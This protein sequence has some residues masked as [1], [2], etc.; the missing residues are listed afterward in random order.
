MPNAAGILH[1]S[2]L[3]LGRDFDDIGMKATDVQR[4]ARSYW[5]RGGLI[6]QAH[7]PFIIASLHSNVRMAARRLGLAEDAFDLM[8]VTGD[9]STTA[10]SE[11]R[12]KFARSFLT[13]SF[14]YENIDI[15]LRFADDRVLCVPGNHDKMNEKTCARYL[16]HFDNLPNKPPYVLEKSCNGVRFVFYGI[17]SNLY[18]EGNVALGKIRTETLAWLADRK[19][20]SQQDTTKPQAVRILLLHHHPCDLNKLRKR[21]L[22]NWF[23]GRLSR[24]E[25]GDRLL[26]LCKGWIDVIMHGHEHFPAAFRDDVSGA[27]VVSAGTTSESH[28][29][30]GRNSFFAL[31]FQDGSVTVSDFRW[32][33]GQFRM[34]GQST[35]P[36]EISSS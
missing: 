5:S 19:D 23:T 11:E 15:G 28:L 24:L 1:L 7:D 18:E 22:K 36:L 35:W 10:D 13:S 27:V 4:T 9:I 12:F 3:H 20:E 14:K 6:M 21:T 32:G 30:K 16:A 17:D 25:D 34:C 29:Q 33:G 2:D 26:D 31:V 8:V